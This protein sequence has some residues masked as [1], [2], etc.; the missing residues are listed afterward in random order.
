MSVFAIRIWAQDRLFWRRVGIYLLKWALDNCYSP[1]VLFAINLLTLSVTFEE[2]LSLPLLS[3]S[4]G[5]NNSIM[6]TIAL[7]N[8][9]NHNFWQHVTW[10]VDVRFILCCKLIV[11]SCPSRERGL[12][13]LCQTAFNEVI[14]KKGMPSQAH[15]PICVYGHP[16]TLL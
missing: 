11:K 14:P 6:S 15:S 16:P 7:S 10:N 12:L 13:G 3:C 4:Q 1:A 9:S 8:M 5:I 2:S